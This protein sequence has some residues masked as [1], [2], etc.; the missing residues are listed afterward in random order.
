MGNVRIRHYRIRKRRGYWEPTARMKAMGFRVM[1]LGPDGPDAWA[2]AE[3]LNAEWDLVRKGGA[4][5][6]VFEHGKLGWLFE[7]YRTMGVWAKKEPRTREEWELAWRIIEPVFA[8]VRADTIDFPACD[9]FY[10]ELGRVFSLHKQHRV[11]KIF[12]A[13]LEVAIGFRLIAANPTHKIANSAPK[14]R[15]EIWREEEVERLRG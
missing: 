3:R 8:D 10:T 7:T 15:K 1:P 5:P 2:R 9:T 13:L 6:K 11:F 4:G 12:R 14:G